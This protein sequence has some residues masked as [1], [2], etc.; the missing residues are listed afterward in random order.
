[1][2]TFISNE[3]RKNLYDLVEAGEMEQAKAIVAVVCPEAL[4]SEGAAKL[5]IPSLLAVQGELGYNPEQVE[6]YLRHP[7]GRNRYGVSI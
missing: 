4:R 7:A 3:I 2:A 1:M 5:V 6:P